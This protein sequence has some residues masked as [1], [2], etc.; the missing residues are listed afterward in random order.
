MLAGMRQ[1]AH[2]ASSF[3]AVPN[4]TESAQPSR[5]DALSV[6]LKG[7]AKVGFL[8]LCIPLVLFGF[9][10]FNKDGAGNPDLFSYFLF[11]IS[12]PV[13]IVGVALLIVFALAIIRRKI[14]AS[15]NAKRVEMRQRKA[16]KNQ[17]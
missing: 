7:M 5:S 8:L 12:I 4:L 17:K 11:F 3:A 2:C 6:E 14:V 16:L 13:G 1:C 9:S 15:A 10:F